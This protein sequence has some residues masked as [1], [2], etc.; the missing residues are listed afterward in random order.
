MDDGSTDRTSELIEDIQVT[1]ERVKIIVFSRNFGHQFAVSAGLEA[2]KGEA[3]VL[4]D[5]DLQDPPL[6]IKLMIKKWIE[7]YDVV[8]GLRQRREGETFFKKFSAKLFFRLINRLSDIPMPKDT[9][10]LRFMDRKVVEALIQMPEKDRF[11]RGM[12]S[13]VGFNQT[14]VYYDRAKRTAGVG[15]YP[16]F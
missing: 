1:D 16:F 10:D 7:G 2:A 14:P 6:V 5:A 11:I 12:I 9:G 15:K 8:Y 3:V 13:W 4:I